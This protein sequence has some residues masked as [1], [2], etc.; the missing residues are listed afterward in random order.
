MITIRNWCKKIYQKKSCNKENVTNS[1]DVSNDFT[2]ISNDN[3]T[4]KTTNPITR[5]KLGVKALISIMEPATESQSSR[6][7][8]Q[9]LRSRPSNKIKVLLDSGSNGI[10]YKKEKTN[11]FPTWLGRH[12]SLGAH[13]MGVSKQMEEASS[14]SNSLSILLA[15]STP[16]NLTLWSMIIIWTNQGLTSFLGAIPWKS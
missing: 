8:K 4:M 10:S 9:P 3:I 5:D 12:Q 11:P 1:H 15:G 13:Q 16:Y 2:N 14:D 6:A 7:Y